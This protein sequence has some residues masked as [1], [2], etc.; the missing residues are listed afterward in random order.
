MRNMQSMYTHTYPYHKHL[1]AHT[2]HSLVRD[3]QYRGTYLE[4]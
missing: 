3:T 4:D 2:Y 1:L